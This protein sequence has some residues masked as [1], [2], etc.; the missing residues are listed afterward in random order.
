MKESL[1][2]ALFFIIGLYSAASFAYSLT[3]FFGLTFFQ[4]T[5]SNPALV[6]SSAAA[7]ILIA[8]CVRQSLR[9]GY[10]WKG[11]IAV[12]EESLKRI[13]IV[14]LV[15]F[16]TGAIYFAARLFAI[17]SIADRTS[18]QSQKILWQEA[19]ALQAIISLP[20]FIFCLVGIHG[21]Y[22]QK[23]LMLTLNPL[24]YFLDRRKK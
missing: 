13:R 24:L 8:I 16:L 23:M 3:L 7:N 14:H 5:I 6:V 12:S 20:H 19:L 9:L 4:W 2:R 11:F 17:A 21:I 1:Q 15:F 18:P 22:S 10:R